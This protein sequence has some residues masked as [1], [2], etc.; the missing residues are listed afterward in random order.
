M[1]VLYVAGAKPGAGATAAAAGLAALW[2]RA[3]HSVAAFKPAALLADAAD[4]DAALLASPGYEPAAEPVPLADLDRAVGAIVDAAAK[5]DVV[6][7]EG[8]PLTDGAGGPVAASTELAQRS[9]AKVVGVQPYA[10][11]GASETARRWHAA[12]GDSL[13]GLRHGFGA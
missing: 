1:G 12:F 6:V 4:G 5:A 7:V 2:R 8:L 11:D 13:A 3:G 10:A 9:G